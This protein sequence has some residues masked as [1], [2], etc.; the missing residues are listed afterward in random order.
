MEKQLPIAEP[1]DGAPAIARE[2]ER[3]EGR[4]WWLW[5]FAVI[6]TV[7]LTVGI[8]SFTLPWFQ[9][10]NSSYWFE[11]KEWMR[12]LAAL[13][14]LFDV[15]T[16]YQH[17]Q[18]YRT[19][20]ALAEQSQL[21]RLISDNAGDMISLADR[22]NRP[23]Y[24][25]P[26]FQK[27]LGYSSEE[28][29][30][31]PLTD[32]VHPDDCERVREA[33]E[34]TRLTGR[35]HRLEYR[36]RHKDGAWRILESTLNAIRNS[37]GEVEKLVIVNRDISERK[38][39]EEMLAHHAFHDALTNLPNRVLF[40]DRLQRACAL[41]K[42]RSNY[43]FAVLFIDIDEFK[44]INESLGHE[45]GDELL[46][47][48][49]RRL[50]ASL[51]AFDLVS[52]PAVSR[53]PE[54]QISDETLAKLPGDEFAV[55]LDDVRDPSDGVRVAER[56]Q[57]RLAAPFL[58][59][60]HEIVISAS[61]GIAQG[62]NDRSGAQDLLR[63]AEIA[64][65]RAKQA[66]K[67]RCEV[68]DSAMHASAVKRLQL[69]TDLRKAIERDEMRVHYQPLI[70]LATGRIVSFEALSRWQR[71]DRLVFPGEYIGVADETGLILPINQALIHEACQ[72]LRIWQEE[73]PSDPPLMMSV[74]ISAR[75]FAL[76]QFPS[77]LA[78]ILGQTG[79]DPRC[80]DVEVLE[81]V[82][83]GNPE[84][85]TRVL[86][87]LKRIGVRLSIDDFGTGY[88]SLS[89]L[90]HLPVETLKIDRS[91]VSR[92]ENEKESREIVRI[93]I[94]LA[95]NLGLKVV[96]EGVETESQLAQ[97]RELNCDFAQGYLFCRPA[98]PRKISEMLANR[99]Y[100]VAGMS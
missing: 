68:F 93:I 3:I 28:L 20:R 31:S 50:T 52:R 82:A 13:V 19:R 70:S 48:I 80:L 85:A 14:L 27:I 23:L 96:A 55:L 60:G 66:G 69:E 88:S 67:A 65:H 16:V 7:V 17:L 59:D 100:L 44:V 25:S 89:R 75:Q 62:G 11:L 6:V 87:E 33:M 95:H 56:I 5:G 32:W 34:A 8:L 46:V 18:L 30:S 72:Q 1:P 38:R 63:D 83:M 45:A 15:Y 49:S 58:V 54:Y 22:D 97:L 77:D 36:I 26:S 10:S 53:T 12:G 71:P 35:G 51:R 57:A 79:V 73:F 61:I 43:Q 84:L 94:M 76:P 98:E 78:A 81:T 2:I 91:F 9:A 39:A 41:S 40:L 86:S 4:E 37:S 99:A 74:N 21:F 90:Q 24:N 64:L 47:Q 42:R 29:R 92:M